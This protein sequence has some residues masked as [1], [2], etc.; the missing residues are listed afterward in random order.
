MSRRSRSSKVVA[1]GLMAAIVATGCSSSAN[2]PNDPPQEQMPPEST[3]APDATEG[4]D[5][6]LEKFYTQTVEWEDC[7]DQFQCSTLTVPLDYEDPEGDEIEVAL[8]RVPASSDDAVGSLVVNPGGPGASGV[9]YARNAHLVASQQILD[10]F[11]VVGFDP[12]GVGSSTPIECLEDQALDDFLGDTP[13]VDDENGATEDDAPED[14][15]EDEN[16]NEDEAAAIEAQAEEFALACESR[17]GEFLEHIGT[18]DVARD[19]DVLRAALGDE[20]LNYLGKSYGTSIGAVYADLFPERSG[21]LVL[22]GAIDPSLDSE[23]LSL[24]QTYGFERA[25]NAFLDWCLDN[26]CPIG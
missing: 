21:R 25:L 18:A 3:P 20:Q 15:G 1:L 2:D 17:S 12:R 6:A 5:T 26:D 13:P 24:G 14:E 4:I 19:M 9:D 23:E 16:D 22:D 11:D 8:L 7:G 10:Q